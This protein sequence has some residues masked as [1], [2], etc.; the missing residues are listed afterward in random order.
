MTTRQTD[1]V[2]GDAGVVLPLKIQVRAWQS[3]HWRVP[4]VRLVDPSPALL[5]DVHVQPSGSTHKKRSCA[6]LS[7]HRWR[8]N[9][10]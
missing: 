5:R 9:F 4:V 3:E 6:E 10:R 8:Q 7:F 2:Q 1:D